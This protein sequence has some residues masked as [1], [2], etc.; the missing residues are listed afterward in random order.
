MNEKWITITGY[1]NYQ[2]S[3]TGLIKN[4]ATNHLLKEWANSR[5]YKYVSLSHKA[6]KRNFAVHRLVAT[7]FVKGKSC[8]KEVNHKDEDKLNN[9][10][11]NLEWISHKDNLNYGHHNQKM[12][13]SNIGLQQQNVEDM[14]LIQDMFLNVA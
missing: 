3:N 4:K 10:A 1:P 13:L 12:R 6:H 5:G 11:N 8:D 7:Y 14:G 2:M 9:Q